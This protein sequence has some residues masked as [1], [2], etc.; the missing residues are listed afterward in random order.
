MIVRTLNLLLY[1]SDKGDYLTKSLIQKLNKCFNENVKFNLQC[2]VVTK[3]IFSFSRK[4]MLFIELRVQVVT[5]NALEKLTE[6][7]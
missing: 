6:I 2:F 4:L 7:F 5:I 3:I 1:L